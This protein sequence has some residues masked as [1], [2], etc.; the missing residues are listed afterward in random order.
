[1]P[2]LYPTPSRL[3]LLRE[4]FGQRVFQD[5]LGDNYVSGERKC[6]AA[7]TEMRAADW[8]R[9]VDLSGDGILMWEITDAG[10]DVL[11]AHPGGGRA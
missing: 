6:N 4:V 2:D 1:M 8:V 3:A 7:I 5:R 10:R 11:D 9:L